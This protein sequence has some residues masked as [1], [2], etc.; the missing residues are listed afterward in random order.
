MEIDNNTALSPVYNTVREG[1]K[2]NGQPVGRLIRGHGQ[3]WSQNARVTF[4]KPEKVV[5]DLSKH[6]RHAD[7]AQSAMDN[8]NI[9]HTYVRLSDLYSKLNVSDKP[10]TQQTESIELLEPAPFYTENK[11]LRKKVVEKS[12]I[13]TPILNGTTNVPLYENMNKI[14][15]GKSKDIVESKVEYHDIDDVPERVK[16]KRGKCFKSSLINRF[17]RLSMPTIDEE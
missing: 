4:T 13:S 17:E 15:S 8:K 3:E 1:A 16:N 14:D 6:Q 5:I 7:G 2:D 12:S 11:K 10:P 9:D